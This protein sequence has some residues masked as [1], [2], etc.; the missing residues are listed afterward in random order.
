MLTTGYLWHRHTGWAPIFSHPITGSV[1]WLVGS[2]HS[3]QILP[4][5]GSKLG[6]IDVPSEHGP[7]DTK[8]ERERERGDEAP[9][10]VLFRPEPVRKN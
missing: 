7:S 3:D 2:F 6:E 8:R 9:L 1:S 4:H 10:P 5:G